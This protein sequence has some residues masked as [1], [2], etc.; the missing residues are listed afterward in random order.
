[1]W[2][3]VSPLTQ[4]LLLTSALVG[5]AIAQPS[6]TL[7]TAAAEEQTPCVNRSAAV[8]RHDSHPQN[9]IHAKG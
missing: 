4:S 8:L 1:M 9:S 5:T 7:T 6:P 3:K 2:I